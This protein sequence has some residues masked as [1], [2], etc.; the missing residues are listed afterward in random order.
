MEPMDALAM[1]LD[2]NLSVEKYDRVKKYTDATGVSVLPNR[3]LLQQAKKDI[4]DPTVLKEKCTLTPSE[5]ALPMGF[6]TTETLE[7][8]CQ[9]EDVK[10]KLLAL[11]PD[12]SKKIEATFYCRLI[13]I[14]V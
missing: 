12:H 10:R 3:N 5:M 4:I 2:C 13:S 14:V 9:C 8:I 11:S 6:V 1:T 7:A